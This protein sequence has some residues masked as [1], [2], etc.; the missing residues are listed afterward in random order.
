MAGDAGRAGQT[1][2]VVDVAIETD[3]RRIGVRIGQGKAHA[4]VIE[5]CVQPSICTVALLASDGE[6]RGHMVW[7]GGALVLRSVAGIALGG[8]PLKLP[9]GGALVTSFT[10]YR[11]MRADERKAILVVTNRG[12]GNLPA[13]D[14]VT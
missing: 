6:S 10:L 11:R 9:C 3:T 2:V 1:V 12:Y 5:L 4:C 8:K 13:F 14:G 7:V